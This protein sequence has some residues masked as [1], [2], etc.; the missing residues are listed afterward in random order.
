M[1]K[2]KLTINN[3]RVD[4]RVEIINVY[5]KLA[6]FSTLFLVMLILI[7]IAFRANFLNFVFKWFMGIVAEIVL[8]FL[9]IREIKKLTMLHR[10]F[11]T[12][13]CIVKDKLINS[14]FKGRYSRKVVDERYHLNFSQYGSYVIPTENYKWS[15]TFSM[16]DTGVYNYSQRDDEFYLVLSKPNTGK[17]LY[18][19]NTKIF[20]FEE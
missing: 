16:S 20:E 8:F 12:T 9:I 3:I 2:E 1:Q 18:V 19:Y 5:K 15:S 13:N 11:K 4:L 6:L 10:C 7:I 17:I 14:E